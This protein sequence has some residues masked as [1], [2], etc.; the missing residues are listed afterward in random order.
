MS[1]SEKASRQT[2]VNYSRVIL[3]NFFFFFVG[4]SGAS[5]LILEMMM[6]VGLNIDKSLLNFLLDVFSFLTFVLFCTLGNSLPE[7][8]AVARVD[9]AL[10]RAEFRDTSFPLALRSSRVGRIMLL[11]EG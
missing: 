6:L 9:A 2:A 3:G 1:I 7:D 11:L 4:D 10:T 5:E 8:T